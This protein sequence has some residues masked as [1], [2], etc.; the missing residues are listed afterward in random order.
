MVSVPLVVKEASLTTLL[1]V[2]ILKL[3]LLLEREELLVKGGLP[4]ADRIL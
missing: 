4:P 2:I 3:S 1:N